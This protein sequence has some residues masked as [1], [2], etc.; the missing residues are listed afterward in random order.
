MFL[1]DEDLKGWAPSHIAGSWCF[2]VIAKVVLVLTQP[3]ADSCV[4]I[5]AQESVLPIEEH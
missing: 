5:T 2:Q 1:S 3:C 4:V